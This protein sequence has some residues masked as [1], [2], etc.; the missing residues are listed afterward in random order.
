MMR[1]RLCKGD[2]RGRLLDGEGG[3]CPGGHDYFD[4]LG[5]QLGD[6]SRKALILSFRPAILDQSVSAL[7]IPE[8][9]QPLTE[10]PD[11]IGLKGRRGVPEEPY[12][13]QLSC[14]LGRGGERAQQDA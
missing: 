7:D 2:R 4:L 6:E 5:D 1:S 3:G 11:E 10:R 13:V 8:V 12:P 9:T 14:L